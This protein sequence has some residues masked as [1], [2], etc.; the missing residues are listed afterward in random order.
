VSTPLERQRAATVAV[1]RADVAARPAGAWADLGGLAVHRT[2][3]PV[4]YWNGA[5]LTEPEGLARLPQATA[6]FG[7]TPWA[8]LAPQERDV[9]LP[10][11]TDQKV[12]LRSLT[13]LPDV[14]D[15][16][17]R[18][19]GDGMLAVQQAA[20]G[21]ELLDAF[22][23]TKPAVSVAALVTAYDGTLPVATARVFCVD[24]VAGVYGVGTVPSHR[25]QG[26]GAA[27]TVAA[28]HEAARRGCDLAFLNPSEL[29]Y[30]M[31]AALGFQDV[32]GWSVYR[33]FAE[34][35]LAAE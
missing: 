35:G 25:R 14:P 1:W 15:L 22:L 7:D 16:E 24:G 30:G 29:G 28:L 23:Q 32:P 33:T 18:W 9:D 20:F 2:G 34:T 27:V 3:L 5:H 11:I 17:L 8:L 13:A 6:W 19:G 12:M 4:V 31:Y 21:D 26:L 10:H